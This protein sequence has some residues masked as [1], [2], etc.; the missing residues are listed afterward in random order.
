M[1]ATQAAV[2]TGSASDDGARQ[3]AVLNRIARIA[4]EDIELRPMLQ[5]IVDALH[6]HYGWEFIACAS[7]D[8]AQDRF[9]CEALHSDLPSDVHVGYSRGLGSGIVGEVALSGATID[10][11]D[12]REHGNF[13]DTLH[14]TRAELCVPVRHH[15]EVLAVLNAESRQVGAFRGQ[16]ALLETV[17]EQIGGVI[18][19]ARL[20]DELR[21]RADLFRVTSEL[22]RAALEV[23]SFEQT[24]ERIAVFIRE[25]FALEI[26]GIFLAGSDGSLT[27]R[28]RAGESTL[29]HMV[30]KRW[31]LERGIALRAFR[32]GE[33][34]FVPDVSLDPDYIV[35]NA[36]VRSELAVPIRLQGRLL[37]V[38]NME[39]AG[40]ESFVGDNRAMLEALA[41][42]VAGAIHLAGSAR[43]LAEMNRLLEQRTLELQS[44]NAQLRH[45]NAALEQLSQRDGL[46]GLANRRRFDHLFGA[47]W[48]EAEHGGGAIG[49]LL[50]D[51]DHF[52]R[53]NDGYGHLAGDD[54]L[55]RVA[56]ALSA[57]LE[58]GDACLARYGGEEF[59]IVV[60][61]AE[62]AQC[63]RLAERLRAG[64]VD[65]G[66]PHAHAPLPL[67]SI[68]VGV[69]CT[70][71]MPG[72]SP[73]TLVA[74][75]DR[76]LYRAKA[77][78]RNRVVV[79]D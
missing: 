27:L 68:S 71:P 75:A 64:V 3:L 39:S 33:S 29:A 78:G 35:G 65:L 22:S 36:R 32:T 41:S 6:E 58:D 34:Q 12:V 23:E 72:I 42:Q 24:L 4:T 63:A 62:A 59:A 79:A 19:I 13:V 31:G 38:I 54:A 74:R 66:M 21:R 16:R 43:R 46:T 51:I 47:L 28:A 52:K 70:R 48:R 17:A 53:Y 8:R 57:A 2:M 50:A 11:D 40:T 1:A 30:G 73:E 7:V 67:V 10:L 56:S 20:H 14:D 55:R 49:L 26:C 61:R 45:A 77:S 44:T 69:A 9:V 5:R 18:A 37:G 76:A 60:P 25:R 15:G